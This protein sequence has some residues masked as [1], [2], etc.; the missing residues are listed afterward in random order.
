MT[1]IS[2]PGPGFIL[3]VAETPVFNGNSPGVVAW[4]DLDLSAVVGAQPA[5][6]LIKIAGSVSDYHVRKNGDADDFTGAIA[7]AWG[8]ASS[9]GDAV[10]HTV[11][12]VATDDAGVIEWKASIINT[13]VQI[14]IIGYVS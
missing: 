6:V 4:T 8:C 13:P 11:L 9:R 10:Q 1:T 3:V 12:L 7:S 14:D 2:N 5:L